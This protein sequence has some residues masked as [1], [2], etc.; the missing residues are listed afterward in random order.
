MYT[1]IKLYKQF[2]VRRELVRLMYENKLGPFYTIFITEWNDNTFKIELRTADNDYT[3]HRFVYVD[4]E[5]HYEPVKLKPNLTVKC[6][7]CVEENLEDCKCTKDDD[8]QERLKQQYSRE[9][10]NKYNSIDSKLLDGTRHSN[11]KFKEPFSP[12]SVL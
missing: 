2:K 12:K 3:I 4:D 6:A 10:E 7:H 1:I 5:Y 8:F 9:L 11:H